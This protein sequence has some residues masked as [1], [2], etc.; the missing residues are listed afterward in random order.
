MTRRFVETVGHAFKVARDHGYFFRGGLK[1][2][3]EVTSM[4][5]VQGKDAV[6]GFEECCVDLYIVRYVNDAISKGKSA[7]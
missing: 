6:V 1:A 5:E 7:S 2:M 4:G 3:R